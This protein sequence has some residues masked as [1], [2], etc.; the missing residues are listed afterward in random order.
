[1]WTHTELCLASTQLDWLEQEENLKSFWKNIRHLL[2]LDTDFG[3]VLFGQHELTWKLSGRLCK[4]KCS[5]ESLTNLKLGFLKWFFR[6]PPISLNLCPQ[7]A[8]SQHRDQRKSLWHPVLLSFIYSLPAV[9]WHPSSQPLLGLSSVL[10]V[11]ANFAF[12]IKHQL[13]FPTVSVHGHSE[14]MQCL[15]PWA[16]Q[17][18]LC[19]VLLGGSELTGSG[20]ERLH[21][22]LPRTSG[23]QDIQSRRLSLD[24]QIFRSVHLQIFRKP[25][26]FLGPLHFH[27]ADCLWISPGDPVVNMNTGNL[28]ASDQILGWK[29]CLTTATR[30]PFPC[31]IQ[32]NITCVWYVVLGNLRTESG[33]RGTG[34]QAFW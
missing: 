28:P 20:Y 6:S 9:V 12:Q 19:R 33:T 18:H 23:C 29:S 14:K 21:Q 5:P 32:Q 24:A 26:A 3:Y 1:M 7:N 27:I 30:D 31:R 17:S 22:A 25:W 2:G 34:S 13:L 11:W 10:A 15:F 8:F 4:S 16:D